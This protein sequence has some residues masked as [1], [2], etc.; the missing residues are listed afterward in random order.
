MPTLQTTGDPADSGDPDKGDPMAFEQGFRTEA[1]LVEPG[2]TFEI[3][4]G[5]EGCIGE[6]PDDRPPVWIIDPTRAP[7]DNEITDDWGLRPGRYTYDGKDVILV[8]MYDY[9]EVA[10]SMDE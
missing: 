8:E 10:D 2:E 4:R 5:W 7:P 9:N 1:R 3:A 6:Q